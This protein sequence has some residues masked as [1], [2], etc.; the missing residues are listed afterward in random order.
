ML[1][2]ELCC[3]V[4][5]L[6]DDSQI[7]A[8]VL[9]FDCCELGAITPCKPSFGFDEYRGSKELEVW[10]VLTSLADVCSVARGAK[11]ASDRLNIR[12]GGLLVFKGNTSF[13]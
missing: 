8:V 7:E 5:T 10:C 9:G 13:S 4:V 11:S 2:F 6:K 1:G 3:P 12:E